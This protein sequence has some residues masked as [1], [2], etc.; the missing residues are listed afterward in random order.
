MATKPSTRTTKSLAKSPTEKKMA[1]PDALALLRADHVNVTGLFEQF[2][3]ARSANQKQKIAAQIC[4]ELK[5][6]AQ[7]E[8]EIFY[9]ELRAATDTNDANDL[10]DEA[11]VE[12]DGAKKLIAEIEASAPEDEL[13]DARVK[14]LSEYIKHHV[15]EEQNNIFPAAR[16][17]ELDLKEMGLRLKARKE[18]LL[19]E[20]KA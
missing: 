2:E 7:L 11:N 3:A 13:F 5:V 10:L 9:P 17:S 14:V 1:H 19:S 18:E 8:E 6:H 16:K 12:H 15:K 20:D 4:D